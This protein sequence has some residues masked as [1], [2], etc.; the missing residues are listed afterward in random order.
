MIAIPRSS[1]VFPPGEYLRDELNERGWTESEFARII[2]RP[3]QAVSE[4]LNGKKEITAETAVA[5]SEALGTSAEL[6]LNLQA[7]YR[8]H[9]ARSRLSG[10]D[11]IARRSRLRSLIP[12]REAQKRGWLPDTED[13][14][15]L[16][17]AVCDFL[18]LSS[19]DEQ[20]N[21]TAAARRSNLDYPFSPVQ[22]AWIAQVKRRGSRTGMKPF[23]RKGIERLAL[24]I[25][26]RIHDPAD[27]GDLDNWLADCGVAMAVELPLKGS[28]IDGVSLFPKGANP[29]VG[30]STRGDRLDSFV[31]TVL[32][33]LAHIVL[34]HVNP[35]EVQ[36]D[37]DLSPE[38]NGGREGAA[39]ELAASWIFPDGLDMGTTKPTMTQIQNAA[40]EHNVHPSFVIGRLQRLGVLAWSDFRRSIPKV[41]PHLHLDPSAVSG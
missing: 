14:D 39:N 31:F 1:E 5:L 36:L 35:G 15:T 26:G 28:K 9:V 29:I 8:L 34:G 10:D 37:E 19:I 24:Q 25:V 6:W 21:F 3:A 2:D 40:R 23:N 38:T 27:L 4:I 11:R 17:D 33:E 22:T 18:G 16:E 32:H 20:P 30:L 13:L 41:R 7:A 12:V